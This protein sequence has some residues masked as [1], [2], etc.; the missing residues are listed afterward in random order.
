MAPPTVPSMAAP[1]EYSSVPRTAP[2]GD[3]PSVL[4]WGRSDAAWAFGRD[5][6][7]ADRF[8]PSALRYRRRQSSASRW[9]WRVRREAA[10]IWA[11]RADPSEGGSAHSRHSERRSGFRTAS[12]RGR[13]R[14]SRA[15]AGDGTRRESV[16]SRASRAFVRDVDGVV[17]R[18]RPRRSDSDR[19]DSRAMGMRGPRDR[20][21]DRD[22]GPRVDSHPWMLL[23]MLL[24]LCNRRPRRRKSRSRIL[25]LH[26]FRGSMERRCRRSGRRSRD[27]GGGRSRRHSRRHR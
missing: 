10:R 19:I 9:A 17:V 11:P 24:M 12:C 23:P 16:A 6:P 27:D 3:A 7:S 26:P 5:P 21:R 20:C 2:R 4:P 15:T 14:S 8:D 1:S 22:D 25:R 18:G 13:R